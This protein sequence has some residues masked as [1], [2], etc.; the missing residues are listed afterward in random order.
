V[1]KEA[2]VADMHNLEYPRLQLYSSQRWDTLGWM[3]GCAALAT[4]WQQDGGVNCGGEGR[5]FS[6]IKILANFI[7]SIKSRFKKI[8]KSLGCGILA[9]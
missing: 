5:S 7:P 3:R 2:F 4:P 1:Y 8:K 9:G 6:G